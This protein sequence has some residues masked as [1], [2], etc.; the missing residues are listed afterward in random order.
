MRGKTPILYLL[1]LIA[2]PAFSADNWMSYDAN[3]QHTS[4][5]AMATDPGKFH[6]IWER[7]FN[8]DGFKTSMGLTWPLAIAD[9]KIF[10]GYSPGNNQDPVVAA[11]EADTGKTLWEAKDKY[12][13]TTPIRELFW[14]DGKLISFNPVVN[15]VEAYDANSGIR[16]YQVYDD[17]FRSQ[18]ENGLLYFNRGAGGNHNEMITG[19]F[20]VATGH[21]RWLT[22]A[23]NIQ[24]NE[25]FSA[26]SISDQYLITR[27]QCSMLWQDKTN[28]ALIDMLPLP[29]CL[30][31]A[32]AAPII[33]DN[34][35]YTIVMDTNHA[36]PTQYQQMSGTLYAIDLATRKIKWSLPDQYP[37]YSSIAIRSL[38]YSMHTIYSLSYTNDSINAIDAKTG[39]IRWSW[40]IP[41]EERTTG[42]ILAA[43]PN[44][45][46]VNGRQHVLAVSLITHQIVWKSEHNADYIYLGSGK[47]IMLRASTKPMKEYLT[48]I[49]LN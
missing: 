14:F 41:P 12:W 30:S 39:Q 22:S 28:G 47:L 17:L 29:K 16:L 31:Y 37:E 25:T 5:V 19:A 3:P 4:S 46:F 20:D 6:Q 2:A 34:T 40:T 7:E 45:L 26:L 8:F 24:S 44:V 18:L 9:G 48:A 33:F 11:L 43:T 10:Y 1:M 32:N 23:L 35:A 21:T 15:L 38:V 42:L 36:A 49:A 13:E 27:L